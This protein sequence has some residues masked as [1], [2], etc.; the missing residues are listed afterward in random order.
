MNASRISGW[1]VLGTT[2]SAYEL[3]SSDSRTSINEANADRIFPVTEQQAM[4]KTFYIETLGWSEAVWD[5][6]ALA[7]GGLPALR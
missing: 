3:D 6:S 2:S 7:A 1:D 4:E 5:F